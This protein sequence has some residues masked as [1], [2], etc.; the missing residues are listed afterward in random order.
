MSL[1]SNNV[2]RDSIVGLDDARIES[3]WER[4][5]S[6]PSTLALGPTQSLIQQVPALIPVVKAAGVWR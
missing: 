5:F 2:D 6:L 3:L 4:D 1:L